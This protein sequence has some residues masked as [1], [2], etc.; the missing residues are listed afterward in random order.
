ML[1]ISRGLF[2]ATAAAFTLV[3]MLVVIT[4]LSV[5]I[6]M[7]LP[8]INRSREAARGVVCANK[9]RQVGYMTIA[10]T[11]DFKG[12][13]PPGASTVINPSTGLSVAATWIGLLCYTGHCDPAPVV[14]DRKNVFLCP[15]NK[16]GFWTQ[17]PPPSVPTSWNLTQGY[18][19]R[20]YSSTEMRPWTI[21][22]SKVRMIPW[23]NLGNDNFGPPAEFLFA[24]DSLLVFPASTN[25]LGQTYLF[26]PV[27]GVYPVVSM[28]VAHARH[29]EK[30]NFLF[31][32][33]SVR[34]LGVADLAGK[35]G[36]TSASGYGK[37]GAN[38]VFDEPGYE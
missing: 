10:Y 21:G 23:N 33:G 24:G 3:E 19:I 16:P 25:H 30:G 7:L 32:D 14:R 28:G 35:Y 9:L 20:H 11:H 15:S 27:S 4:I 13:A 5:L 31:G 29:N 17:A 34:T 22:Q 36:D 12:V 37:F 1:P 26:D 38:F 8:S 6:S 2:R 18:G